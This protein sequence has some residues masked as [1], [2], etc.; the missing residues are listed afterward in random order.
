MAKRCEPWPTP[1]NDEGHELPSNLNLM[2]LAKHENSVERRTNPQL[3]FE[4][5]TRL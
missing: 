4:H 5:I 2:Q 1:L 3:E